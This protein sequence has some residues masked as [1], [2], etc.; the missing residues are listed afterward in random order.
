M[1]ALVQ[2][3][4]TARQ[5]Y[6]GKFKDATC[7]DAHLV[8]VFAFGHAS[9]EQGLHSCEEIRALVETLQR[10]CIDCAILGHESIFRVSVLQILHDCQTL[11]HRHVAISERRHLA[12]WIDGF[13]CVALV[14]SCTSGTTAGQQCKAKQSM[15]A[16]R[17]I[18]ASE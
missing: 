12:T 18:A 1:L 6:H 3:N 10:L 14:L 9:E 16:G 2:L 7:T 11:V 4:C 13:D 17:S 15:S 5:A 8:I